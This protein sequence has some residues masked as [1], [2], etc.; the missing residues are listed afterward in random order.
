MA[1]VTNDNNKELT[2]VEAIRLIHKYTIKVN[3]AIKIYA[4]LSDYGW[5]PVTAA[6]IENFFKKNEV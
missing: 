3:E 6:D 5:E 2:R 4:Y 1:Q